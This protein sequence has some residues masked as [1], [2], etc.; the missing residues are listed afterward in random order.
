MRYVRRVYIPGACYFFTVVT[1]QRKSLLCTEYAI[2]RLRR[3][4]QL[5]MKKYPFQMPAI[6][7][8]PDHLH[9]L[10]HLPENDD[11]FSKRW[12]AIKHYFSTG[13]HSEINSRREKKIWQP[14]FWEH[15]I[16]DERDWS[17]HLD[18]IHY[19]PVKHGYVKR[20]LDWPHSSFGRYVREGYYSSDWGDHPMNNIAEM[21]YE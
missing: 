9:C 16:R 13:M 11:N 2:T 7:I 6:V 21:E 1:H 18:Y 3:A 12:L 8:L 15:V 20:P 10:W 17:R 4:F 19:N 14:R 5:A